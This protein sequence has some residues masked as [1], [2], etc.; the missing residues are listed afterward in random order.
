MLDIKY[1][2]FVATYLVNWGLLLFLEI[3]YSV[4]LGTSLKEEVK[5][6]PDIAVMWFDTCWNTG[7]IL[8]HLLRMMFHLRD[9]VI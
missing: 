2:I 3:A 4:H 7:T 1:T 5:T 6:M 8:S 9:M